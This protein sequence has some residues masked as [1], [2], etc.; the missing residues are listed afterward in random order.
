VARARLRKEREKAWLAVLLAAV[1]G[2]VDAVGFLTLAH[3]FT[4][5][6]SGNTV[7]MGAYLGQRQ[8]GE[9]FRRGFPIPLF[10]LGVVCGAGVTETAVRRG[11]RS[12]LTP[13]FCLEALL[14]IAF[15]FF[16]G[17]LARGG[18]AA[19]GGPEFYTLAALLA[20]A[21]G[22]QSATLRR[23]GHRTIRTTYVT[24]M[25]TNF[26]EQFVACLF[27]LGAGR[28]GRKSPG[29][30]KSFRS[31]SRQESSSRMLLYGGVWVGYVCGAALAGFAESRW[32]A[33]SLL[34]P[35]GGL[36]FVIA[37][38]LIRPIFVP[39]RRAAKAEIL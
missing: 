6:M 36:L 3:L 26:G 23:V 31:S 38:D 5:H 7:G 18:G 37:L 27:W 24:G 22:L 28:R 34:L 10:V 8:W 1:A 12:P 9:A 30:L 29:V 20:F 21:M 39:P 32:A 2:S 16:G 11:A 25:L 13:A 4:A 15:V 19:A 33:R 17:G 35:L 14:L